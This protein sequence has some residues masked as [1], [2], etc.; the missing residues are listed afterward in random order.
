MKGSLDKCASVPTSLSQRCLPPGLGLSSV[1]S[2][3]L[4]E[5]LDPIFQASVYLPTP[6]H[7]RSA[8]LLFIR[9]P[10]PGSL[11]PCR[12]HFGLSLAPNTCPSRKAA[13]NLPAPGFCFSIRLSPAILLFTT[14]FQNSK[15][16][17]KTSPEVSDS[18]T[19]GQAIWIFSEVHVNKLLRLCWLLNWIWLTVEHANFLWVLPGLWKGGE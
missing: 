3:M 8:R 19:N 12:S 15:N 16:S 13:F 9:G 7:A 18:L 10:A 4:E 14:Y 2:V 6:P 5:L 17:Y 11:V 1:P